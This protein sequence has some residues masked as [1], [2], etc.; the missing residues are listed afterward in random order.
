MKTHTKLFIALMIA[1]RADAFVAPILPASALQTEA[2]TTT[3]L[4]AASYL[5]NLGNPTKGGAYGRAEQQAS[6]QGG[7]RPES[8][9]RGGN[10]PYLQHLPP[11][12]M[13]ADQN[14]GPLDW[15]DD[16]IPTLIQGNSL[17]TWAIPNDETSRV[18][19]SLRSE[20]RP[21]SSEVEL[22]VGPNYTPMKVKVYSEDGNLRPFNAIVET[23][24]ASNTI[25]V[26]NTAD[27]EFPFY[28][29]LEEYH[30]G[31]THGIATAAA[32]S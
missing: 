5:D 25:A 19:L 4:G 20:G 31:H 6:T 22:W 30:S 13:Y 1:A 24:H 11:P 15:N 23:P 32:V 16:A 17:R 18:K 3:L 8:D 14:G 9:N 10:N 27:M 7:N 29:N 2:S 12:L 26:Y 21:L 28:A